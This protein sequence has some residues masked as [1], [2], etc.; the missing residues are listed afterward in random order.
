MLPPP[1]DPD[2]LSATDPGDEFT[3]AELARF[4]GSQEKELRPFVELGLIR[5]VSPGE[6]RFGRGDESRT[7][8]LREIVRSGVNPGQLA[9]ADRDGRFSLD[10]AG[11]II[12]DPAPRTALPHEEAIARIGLDPAFARRMQESLGLPF[13]AGE[14]PVRS[15]DL[16][17]YQIAFTA[18]EEGIESEALLRLFRVFGI[19]IRQIVE[20]QRDLYRQ[21]VEDPLISAGLSRLELLRSTAETR[22]RLQRLGYRAVFLLLRRLLEQVVYENVFARIE[23]GLLEVGIRQE[24]SDAGRTIVFLDLSGFTSLTEQEGDAIAADHG[25]HLLEIA[26]EASARIGG[27]V[28]KTLGDGLMLH[29]REISEA[30]R[31]AL[32]VVRRTGPKNGMPTARAGVA[33]GPV[34]MRDGDY[35]GRTVN[36]AARLVGAAAPCEVWISQSVRDFLVDLQSGAEHPVIPFPKGVSIVAKGPRKLKGFSET[37]PVWAISE[38]DA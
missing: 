24:R 23:E 15:D 17:L 1:S 13:V 33:T 2:S 21:N 22:L 28:V 29:F 19:G 11:D 27:R 6:D 9:E 12:A 16:E 8:L 4:V 10:F 38:P 30:V 35:F 26:Q 32:D 20:A 7:R 37:I 36:L 25:G 31:V 18:L 3:L 5:P 14:A 34:V